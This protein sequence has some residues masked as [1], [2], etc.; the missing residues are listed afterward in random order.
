M[1]GVTQVIHLLH[2]HPLLRPRLQTD[3]ERLLQA[4][5]GQ[6][7][8]LF[9]VFLSDGAPSDHKE[10][11]CSHGIMV[12]QADEAG[13]RLRDGRAMLR[14]CAGSGDDPKQAQQCRAQV[15]EEVQQSCVRI[16]QRIGQTYGTDRVQV[17]CV[18]FGPPDEDYGVLK[19]MAGALPRGTFQV[20]ATAWGPRPPMPQS[21]LSTVLLGA[22][23]LLHYAVVWCGVLSCPVAPC[24]AQLP[25]S[26]PCL[27]ALSLPPAALQTLGLSAIN[28]Q[29][30]FTSLS[31]T[32]GSLRSEALASRLAHSLT[33]RHEL[34]A[35]GRASRMA[36]SVQQ[37]LNPAEWDYYFLG[38]GL[39]SKHAWDPV[40]KALVP[41]DLTPCQHALPG[42]ICAYGVA[43]SKQHFGRGAERYAFQFTEVVATAPAAAAAPGLPGPLPQGPAAPLVFSVG[44]RMVSKQPKYLEQLADPDFDRTFLRIQGVC[45]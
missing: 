36:Y 9:L 4:D 44:Q 28:L 42:P 43:H 19:A 2:P 20:G 5:L 22:L 26:T 29:A 33:L 13:A 35:C 23:L 6:P 34:N 11:L 15:K 45:G 1:P 31:S 40:R 10:T 21:L 38:D 24:C 3:A 39:V 14:S 8:Q 41:Q 12:W 27:P 25:W 30:A 17:H 18:A 7:T 16:V 37:A 32:L